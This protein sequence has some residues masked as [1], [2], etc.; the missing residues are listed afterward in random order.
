MGAEASGPQGVLQV[1]PELGGSGIVRVAPFLPSTGPAPSTP[2]LQ[3]ASVVR[4]LGE[5]LQKTA[6]ERTEYARVHGIQAVSSSVAQQMLANQQVAQGGEG[7]GARG[8][9]A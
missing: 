4:D 9:L 1:A 2:I 7:E 5:R 8:I 6:A 3:L